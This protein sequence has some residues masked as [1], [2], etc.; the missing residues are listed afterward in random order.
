MPQTCFPEAKLTSLAFR[1]H[2]IKNLLNDLD[3]NGGAGPDGIFPLFLQKTDDILSSKIAVTFRKWARAGILCTC[4]K[5]GNVMPLCKFESDSSC[6]SDYPPITITPVLSK[7]LEHLLAKR[8][9]AFAV[10][11][12]LFPSLQF[13]YHR[14]LIHVIPFEYYQSCSKG[15]GSCL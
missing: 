8:F 15:V 9:N 10:K 5:V 14:D 2:E 11:S 1:S 4:W 3:A 12:N 7:V 6:P 13:G